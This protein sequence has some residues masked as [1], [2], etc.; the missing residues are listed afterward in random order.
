RPTS[1]AEAAPTTAGPG[2]AHAEPGA[3]VGG[4]VAAAA[5]AVAVG[6]PVQFGAAG[7]QPVHAGE[8]EVGAGFAAQGGVDVAQAAVVEVVADLVGDAGPGRVHQDR[9]VQPADHRQRV[10]DQRHRAAQV[11]DHQRADGGHGRVDA[12]LGVGA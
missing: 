12:P 11:V 4:E 1:A 3:G 8:A 9:I 5:A 7:V 6:D 10:G 2:P